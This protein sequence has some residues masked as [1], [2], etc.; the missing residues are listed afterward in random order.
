MSQRIARAAF[1]AM[2]PI[3]AIQGLWL[4]RKA[5][6]LPGAPGARQGSTGTGEPLHLLA[7]GDSIID[8]VGTPDTSASLPVQFADAL[9]ERS[10]RRVHW[11]IEGETGVDIQQL[12]ERLDTIE[13]Q[14][15]AQLVLLSIGVNDVT[16]LS[17]TRHWRRKLEQLL[18]QLDSR[19]PGVRV[20]FAGLPP[21]SRFPLPPQPLRY[22]LGLRAAT[23]DRI[24][25]ELISK[26]PN[27]VHV[28]TRIN[29]EKHGFCEDGFHPSAE[30]CTLWASELAEI[31][32]RREPI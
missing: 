19:W 13:H 18:G 3:T 14:Q 5:T 20:I 28:P 25:A 23:L 21:M 9:A 30:S 16:G 1:W 32:S 11:R 17:S 10:G 7:L 8:G 15:P 4:R 29:P 24:S 31:E 12:L 6:R 26:Y 2:L 22:S 27:A